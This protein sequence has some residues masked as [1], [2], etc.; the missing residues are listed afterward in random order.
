[1]KVDPKADT[2]GNDDGS[3]PEPRGKN[4]TVLV[5]KSNNDVNDTTSNDI[6]KLHIK[7]IFFLSIWYLPSLSFYLPCLLRDRQVLVI[8]DSIPITLA[9]THSCIAPDR[10]W[11][12]R[13]SR[14]FLE[15]TYMLCM[16]NANHLRSSWSGTQQ[17]SRLRDRWWSPELLSLPEETL[18]DVEDGL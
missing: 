13:F 1:M 18:H 9:C 16:T 3:E 15:G 12:R 10:G 17:A 4:T 14:S 8:P 2:L 7:T 11:D 6:G 5:I